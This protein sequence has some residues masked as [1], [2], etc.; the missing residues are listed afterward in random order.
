MRSSH[1][2]IPEEKVQQPINSETGQHVSEDAKN[3]GVPERVWKL[4]EL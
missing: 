4:D 1:P 2:H 3:E